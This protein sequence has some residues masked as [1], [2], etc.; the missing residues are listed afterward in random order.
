[1]KPSSAHCSI[2]AIN[3]GA[4]G[5]LCGIGLEILLILLNKFPFSVDDLT[6]KY[7]SR[8]KPAE[9]NPPA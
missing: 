3:S 2:V 9:G 7:P 6:F 4:I 8:F 1:M 5:P